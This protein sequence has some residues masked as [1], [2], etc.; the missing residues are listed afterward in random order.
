MI[1]PTKYGSST[2]TVQGHL[3]GTEQVKLHVLMTAMQCVKIF[4]GAQAV[5]CTQEC[6][7]CSLFDFRNSLERTLHSP[8]EHGTLA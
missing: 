3:V 4:D 1:V 5:E 2:F 6:T 7:S 8:R